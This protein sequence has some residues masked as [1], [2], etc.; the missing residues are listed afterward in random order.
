M[1]FGASKSKKIN[2]EL[3]LA[4]FTERA[5]TQNDEQSEF[6][7]QVFASVHACVSAHRSVLCA[8]L[9]SLPLRQA[10]PVVHCG[11]PLTLGDAH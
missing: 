10:A 8:F 2:E 3:T 4:E 5:N 11:W 9:H 6:R 7:I 1:E